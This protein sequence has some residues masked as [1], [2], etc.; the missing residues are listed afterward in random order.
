MV[1]VLVAK[2]GWLGFLNK[3]IDGG[4]AWRGKRLLGD[5]KTWRG[6]VSGTFVAGML[7]IV[8]G[9][10]AM[11]GFDE[12]GQTSRSL[13]WELFMRQISEFGLLASLLGLGALLGDAVE[14]FFKRQ[15]A[16]VQPGVSWFPWD[17]VDY[18]LGGM[19][20]SMFFVGWSVSVYLLTFVIYFGLHL[21]VSYVG[22]LL[23]FKEK[24]I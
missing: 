24:A 17:Q 15:F 11:V 16:N 1:P 7:G 13:W 12:Y 22:Y 21:G 23:G 2:W 10:F 19:L 14:S 4:R 8:G 3:P 9:V 20:F 6:L 18:I 5:H